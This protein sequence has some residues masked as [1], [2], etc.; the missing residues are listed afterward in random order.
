M[1]GYIVYNGDGQKIR[2]CN[3]LD[4][5]RAIV[6]HINYGYIKA[7]VECMMPRASKMRFRTYDP[8]HKKY[9]SIA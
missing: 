8:R 6:R 1:S 5:A 2:F 9:I 7:L 4:T 3:D